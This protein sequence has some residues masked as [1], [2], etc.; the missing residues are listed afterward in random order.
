MMMIPWKVQAVECD[1]SLL[2]HTSYSPCLPS[3]THLRLD[4][5]ET[6]ESELRYQKMTVLTTLPLTT[7]KEEKKEQPSF[8]IIRRIVQFL[9]PERAPSQSD[10]CIGIDKIGDKKKFQTE[11]KTIIS[12]PFIFY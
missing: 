3:S 7:Q 11:K 10:A 4:T 12:I 2:D 5:E 6:P 9:T 8:R 1:A